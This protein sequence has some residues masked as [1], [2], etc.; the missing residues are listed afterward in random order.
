MSEIVASDKDSDVTAEWDAHAGEWALLC[1]LADC[2]QTIV[3]EDADLEVFG[4]RHLTSTRHLT[5][6]AKRG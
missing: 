5:S 1:T 6:R 4:Q 2:E 3:P